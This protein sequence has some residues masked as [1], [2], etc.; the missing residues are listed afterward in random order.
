MGEREVFCS[1]EPA[2]DIEVPPSEEAVSEE[3]SDVGD[4]EMGVKPN[5]LKYGCRRA[6]LA[7]ILWSPLK[8]KSFGWVCMPRNKGATN[9]EKPN[10]GVKG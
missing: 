7:D 2:S 8:I 6:L 3:K 10:H 4:T 5:S 9:T 1:E